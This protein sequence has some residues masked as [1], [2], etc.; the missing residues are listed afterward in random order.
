MEA[1]TEPYR[2]VVQAPETALLKKFGIV[3]S[4]LNYRVILSFYVQISLQDRHKN[5]WCFKQAH[6]L[7]KLQLELG[8]DIWSALYSDTL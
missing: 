7:H 1:T 3:F 6:G 2:F 4:R 8:D 5:F